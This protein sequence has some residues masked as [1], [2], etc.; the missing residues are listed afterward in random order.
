MPVAPKPL[1]NMKASA[2]LTALVLGFVAQALPVDNTLAA[3]SSK[4]YDIDFCYDVDA[5]NCRTSSV[6]AGECCQSF[7]P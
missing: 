3:A 4:W 2:A 5:Y 6:I 7:P 1:V